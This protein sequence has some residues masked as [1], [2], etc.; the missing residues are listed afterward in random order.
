MSYWSEKQ[1][2]M[3]AGPNLGTL[4]KYVCSSCVVDEALEDLVEE[5]ITLNN[6]SYCDGFDEDTH[7]G[8]PFDVVMERI[9]ETISSKYANA[10]DLDM[11]WVEGGWLTGE[12]YTEE[13]VGDFDPGWGCDFL[14]DV[15]NCLDPSTYWAEHSKGDWAVVDPST[16]LNY[17][18]ESFK[19]Q[20]LTKTRY[21]VLSEPEDEFELGR[22][23]YIP[24]SGMLDALGKVFRDYGLIVELPVGE[25]FFRVR[26]CSKKKEVFDTFESLGVPPVG[27]AS[28][29]RMNPAGISYFYIARDPE[30]ARKEVLFKPTIRHY[31]GRFEN[32]ESIR[33]IDFVNLPSMPSSFSKD[34]YDARHA[35]KFLHALKA[36][37]IK[38]VSKDGREHI[39][40]IPTQIISEYFRYRFKDKEGGNVDGFMYPSVKN[41]GGINIVVFDSDNSS[42]KG[43]FS[44]VEA[45]EC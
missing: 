15:I 27:V 40:Y 17:G 6:C 2:E 24:I 1:I 19:Q 33:L 32:K 42:L 16:A 3:D 7:C 20:V 37:I 45:T 36:D 25:S 35:V 44:L 14:N 4:D 22:P 28:G 11:P 38:P 23:D 26:A 34:S 12:I 41:D 8:A 39:D 30:T 13:V 43:A 10:Q 5:H 9:Y 29:G 21:L 31:L 18:W